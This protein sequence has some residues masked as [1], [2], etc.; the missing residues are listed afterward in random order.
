[1]ISLDTI[2]EII[3]KVKKDKRINGYLLNKWLKQSG[4]GDLTEFATS[5]LDYF[6]DGDLKWDDLEPLYAHSDIIPW[7]YIQRQ[8][9]KDRDFFKKLPIKAIDKFTESKKGAIMT[10]AKEVVEMLDFIEG[11]VNEEEKIVNDIPMLKKWLKD[12]EGQL[13]KGN[14]LFIID[15]KNKERVQKVA[16]DIIS[17]L[18]MKNLAQKIILMNLDGIYV[19]AN[20]STF[21]DKL[22]SLEIVDGVTFRNIINKV[23]RLDNSFKFV[24]CVI[25]SDFNI[26]TPSLYS[27]IN[28]PILAIAVSDDETTD[29]KVKRDL[30]KFTTKNNDLAIS[31]I[32]VNRQGQTRLVELENI[33]N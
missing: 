26:S 10:K 28:V 4:K 11:K 5:V 1:M 33:P 8:G 31:S 20:V 18:K 13:V 22:D 14:W 32:V 6:K 19:Q 29:S 3:E 23:K 7:T 27:A 21:M 17:I 9:K 30:I 24:G 2:K 16:K 12:I 25:I 15:T